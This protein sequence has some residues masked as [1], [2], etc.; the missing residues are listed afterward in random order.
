MLRST[1]ITVLLF[2][3]GLSL[4]LQNRQDKSMWIWAMSLCVNTR[5]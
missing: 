2:L 3:F 4:L 1:D 5:N